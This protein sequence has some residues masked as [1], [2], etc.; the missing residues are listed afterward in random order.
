MENLIMGKIRCFINVINYCVCLKSA[1]LATYANIKASQKYA[2]L[3]LTLQIGKHRLLH[4]I[5]R[6]HIPII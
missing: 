1:A 5:S 6:V 2:T 3:T 4:K